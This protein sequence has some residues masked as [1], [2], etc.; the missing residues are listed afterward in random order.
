MYL[1]IFLFFLYPVMP[2]EMACSCLIYFSPNPLSLQFHPLMTVNVHASPSRKISFLLCSLSLL[3]A[4]AF[5]QSYWWQKGSFLFGAQGV[6]PLSSVFG[7]VP[8]HHGLE[9]FCFYQR[10][11]SRNTIEIWREAEKA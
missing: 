10:H 5:W 3:A 6:D 2:T 9:F 8:L 4:P 11:A 1:A 7:L